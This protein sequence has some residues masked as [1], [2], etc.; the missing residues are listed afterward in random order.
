MKIQVNNKQNDN[1]M[2][3][4]KAKMIFFFLHETLSYV[5]VPFDCTR[6]VWV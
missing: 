5:V 6:V 1:D 2:P 4:Q 3:F